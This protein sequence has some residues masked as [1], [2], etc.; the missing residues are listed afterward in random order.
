MSWNGRE[1]LPDVQQLS[2]GPP[3][4]REALPVVRECLG[5]PPGCPGVPTRCLVAP[6]GCQV[7]VDWLSR[8]SETGWEGIPDVR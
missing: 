8:M 1:A 3:D 6:T 7:L 2:G 5:D 4:V